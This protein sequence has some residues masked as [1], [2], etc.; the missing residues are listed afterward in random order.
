MNMPLRLPHPA[1]QRGVASLIVVMV[2]LFVVSLVAAYTSRNL[3]FEQ[4]TSTNQY[5]ATQAL[6]AAEAGL[7]WTLSM[8]NQGRI[9]TNC[10]NSASTTPTTFRGRYL[11]FDTTPAS[12][13]YGVVSVVA[14]QVAAGAYPT[15]I[16]AGSTWNCSCPDNTATPALTPPADG[17]VHPTFR[18]RFWT[19][20]PYTARPGLVY[21]EVNGCTSNSDTCLGF[22]P[23]SGGIA[24]EGRATVTALV[25]LISGLPAI[26]T[27]AVTARG[28]VNA[29]STLG[30]TVANGDAAAGV[31]IQ[32]GGVVT[33]GSMNL[34]S[35]PG[36][37]SSSAGVVSSDPGLQNLPDANAMFAS[38][39][40]MN[41]LTYQQQQAAVEIDCGG[42]CNGA[43]LRSYTTLNPGRVFWLNGDLNLDSAGAVGSAT[44]PVMVYVTGSASIT[45]TGVTVNGVIYSAAAD[46][47]FNDASS[48][49]V[50]G[51][52]IA[53]GNLAG[54][55][56]AAIVY[57]PNILKLMRFTTGS[58]VRVPG[59]WK[60]WKD[61][62]A[63]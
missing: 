53:E 15:C 62:N 43:T 46:W 50:N 8:L 35:A 27:A 61:V 29:S 51:A 52:I 32:A 21:V 19:R 42:T 39:F 63:P 30:L 37:P 16:S 10:D 54:A 58:F 33:P 11:A 4:R 38:T 18:V 6:E 44:E 60:D 12:P 47:T 34:I 17:L 31:T 26:P 45:A 1:A 7:E 36:T 48:G 22:G 23:A 3:I 55:S 9:D 14:S 28:T 49:T 25:S 20:S 56:T 5:R 2:L 41:R 24:D 57:D 13:N 59:G 40:N